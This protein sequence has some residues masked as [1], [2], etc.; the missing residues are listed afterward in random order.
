VCGS[1]AE[2]VQ[3][4]RAGPN[5]P[6]ITP[7]A[8]RRLIAI[9]EALASPEGLSRPRMAKQLRV[10]YKTVQRDHGLL[11]SVTGDPGVYQKA[12]DGTYWWWHSDRRRRVFARWLSQRKKRKSPK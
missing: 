11:R 5:V 12:D 2:H 10:A 3:E 1:I 6:E 4:L 7:R 9:D 8:L